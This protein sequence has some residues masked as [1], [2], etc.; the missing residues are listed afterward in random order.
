MFFGGFVLINRNVKAESEFNTDC[1]N[2]CLMETDGGRVLKSK[3]ADERVSP[4]SITKIMTLLIACE[5]IKNNKLNMSDL[6]T[7]SAYAKSMGGSQVFLEEGETQTVEDL[8]KCIVIASGNDASVALAEH[9]CGSEEKFVDL[10]NKKAEE[11]NMINTH[12]VDCCGLTDSDEHYTSAKDVAI[13]S[14]ELINKY[15]FILNYSS[16]WMDKIIHKTKKGT[17]EFVLSNTNKLLKMNSSVLGLKTGSTSKA[18]YCVSA[19]AKSDKLN[20]I[21]VIMGADNNKKR[22]IEADKL[23]K[24]GLSNYKIYEL[25]KHQG[26]VKV[27]KGDRNIIEYMEE[28]NFTYLLKKDESEKNISTR[29]LQTKVDAPVNKGE[30]VGEIVYMYNGKEIAKGKLLAKENVR[31]AN[32]LNCMKKIYYR[33]LVKI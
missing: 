16:T 24:Y 4:A 14:R 7:T 10:M 32:I 12:F 21:S 9:I 20:L 2:Y 13:M 25:K 3:N 26:I 15:P 19:Y 5:Q 33:L 11:L 27:S 29:M 30:I 22:F 6:V 18:G 23:I 8:L 31:K 28:K 1:E 17:K